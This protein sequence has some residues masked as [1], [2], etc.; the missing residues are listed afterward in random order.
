MAEGYEAGETV[1]A[2]ARRYGLSP[3]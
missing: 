1:C 2:V 3:A